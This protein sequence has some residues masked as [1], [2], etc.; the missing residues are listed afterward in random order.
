MI[1]PHTAAARRA[2]DHLAPKI[3]TLKLPV[4]S[5]VTI[6]L[7]H[8]RPASLTIIRSRNARKMVIPANPTSSTGR[9]RAATTSDTPASVVRRRAR[10]RANYHATRT[11]V[12]ARMKAKQLAA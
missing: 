6:T 8:G 3:L 5:R 12:L 11:A 4:G 10:I 2:R 9:P 7:P 1:H